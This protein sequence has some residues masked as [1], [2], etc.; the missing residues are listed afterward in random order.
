M[1]QC[2]LTET[3]YYTV[4]FHKTKTFNDLEI[5]WL[6]QD[7]YVSSI[8]FA[9][10]LTMWTSSVRTF[11]QSTHHKTSLL[12]QNNRTECNISGDLQLH[13]ISSHLRHKPLTVIVIVITYT[14]HYLLLFSSIIV[15]PF[16]YVPNIYQNIF[17]I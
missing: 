7:N 15:L 5:V 11:Y 14:N 3:K 8:S 12:N 4:N 6:G 17:F 1:L 9:H 10:L 2:Q 16:I 13:V